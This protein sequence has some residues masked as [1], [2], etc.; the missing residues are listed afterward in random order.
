M[1]ELKFD[2]KGRVTLPKEMRKELGQR[3]YAFR[4]KDE[5]I[6]RPVLKDPLKALRE[7]GKKLPKHMT[8]KE[9]KDEARNSAIK[10]LLNK[11]NG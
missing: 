5:I 1:P 10:H 6:L 2:D 8:I 11:H 3:F 4:T 9:I 7:E